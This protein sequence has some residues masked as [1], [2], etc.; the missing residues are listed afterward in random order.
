M[1]PSSRVPS[2]ARSAALLACLLPAAFLGAC[3]GGKPG[4][5]GGAAAGGPGGPGGGPPQAMPV[6][7]ATVAEAPLRDATEYVAT[8]KSRH[9]TNVQP[10]VEGVLTRIVVKSGDHVAAGAPLM[11]IDPAKQRAAVL[12]QEATR[13]QKRAALEYARQQLLRMQ[14]LY[15][16]GAV[17]K[18]Q[19]DEAQ[20]ALE[21]AQA[22]YDALGAQVKEQQVQLAYYRVTAPTAGVVG[23]IPVRTG[24]RVTTSTLL[25]TIDQNDALE[26]YISVPLEHAKDLKVGLPVEILGEAGGGE[27]GGGGTAAGAQPGGGDTGGGVLAA[28]RIYFISPQV[29]QQTQEVLVKAPVPN[30][31]RGLRADQFVHARVVWSTHPGVVVPV[32]AVSRVNGQYFV[33]VAEAAPA[34][35]P[36][37]PGG[38]GGAGGPGGPGGAGG[39][40]GPGPGGPGGGPGGPGGGGLVAHQRPIKI[41]DMVGNDYVVLSGLRPGERI[42]A[43]GVQKLFDGMPVAELP[44][45]PPGSGAPGGA[46]APGSPG[47]PRPGA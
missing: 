1:N 9:T 18:Q 20:S 35:G 38:P 22:D 4:A 40:G 17:S 23:D 34:G 2:R 10:Q 6:P 24:D 41:G 28:S 3:G 25:T 37:G 36:G 29:D 7:M 5:A 31:R 19:L 33:F 45:A 11:Q 47:G 44:A 46:G 13:A 30:G 43:S 42:V 27:P 16:G 12:S 32:L 21:Q 14:T 15:K 26:V 8:L 39:A